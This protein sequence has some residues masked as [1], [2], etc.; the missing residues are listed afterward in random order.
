M[1][2]I[3]FFVLLVIVLVSLSWFKDLLA[4]DV[5]KLTDDQKEQLMKLYKSK[6]TTQPESPGVY[7]TPDIFE[8]S[9]A[10]KTKNIKEKLDLT[11]PLRSHREAALAQGS[12]ALSSMTR[13]Q[14]S[15]FEDLKPFGYDLFENSVESEAPVDIAT[16]SDYVLGPGDNILVYLWGRVEKEFNLTF[17][18]EG[19]VFVPQVGEIIGWG[20]TLE[21]FKT[22]AEKQFAKAY[23]DFDL[24]ISLGKIRSIRIYVTGEVKRPGAYTVSSLT[25]LFNA[26][27]AAG[28]PNERGSMRHIKLMRSGKPEAIVDLYKFLL[29]GDNSIDARLQTGDLIFVPV[30]GTRVA[31]RGEIKRP[32]LYELTGNETAL[33]LLELAGQP[34]AEAHLDRVMLERVS[35]KAEWEVIDLNLNQN[36][37]DSIRNQVLKDGDRVTIFSIFDFKRNMVAIAGHVKHPGYYERDDT[38]R[39]SDLIKQGQLQL[40]D[41][42]YERADLFRRHTNNRTEIIPINLKAALNNDEKQNL[43]LQDLDSLQVY[44][45]DQVEWDRSVYIEGEVK[46]PGVYKL[47]DSMTVAD[48][49]FLAGSFKRSA[50]HHEAE[51]ARID[52]VGN[53]QIIT[54]DLRNPQDCKVE[55]KEDDQLYIRRIPEWRENR[56]VVIEGEVKYPGEYTLTSNKETLYGILQRAGGFAENAFPDGLLLER[57]S[58]EDNLERLKI[59]KLVERSQPIVEDTLGNRYREQLFEYDPSSMRRIVIDINKVIK[60]EGEKGDITLE[61]GDHIFVP[62]VPSGVSIMG[63]VGANGTILYTPGKKTDHYIKLAG[64]FT[65]QADKGEVRLV[66]ANGEVYAGGSA[67]GQHIELGDMIVV[68]TKIE[69]KSGWLKNFAT[70]ISAATGI[71]TSAYIVSKL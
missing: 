62:K 60:T 40:Y 59:N 46:R 32:A 34:T 49:V 13:K 36:C 18:R 21:Q 22:R 11:D 67:R 9:T 14:M 7:T 53:V 20:L 25:S 52:A 10:A 54:V 45:I 51:I 50:D 8:D 35:G 71:L 24:T 5:S 38:T 2:K 3:L 55:L 41:V 43:V 27:Y 17:D 6:K 69:R 44:S 12:T 23:S 30:A 33:D 42:Y 4:Q 19:K 37:P 39:V 61:P 28:G 15:N 56:S 1:R 68:P 48:L 47:Y 58:I 31:I 63:A 64:N 29:E 66:K 65:K 26:I 16:T 57:G 70:A